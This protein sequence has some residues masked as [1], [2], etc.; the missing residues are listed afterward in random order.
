MPKSSTSPLFLG[1]IW[2]ICF[3]FTIILLI[4]VNWNSNNTIEKISF[5]NKKEFFF[6]FLYNEK[7]WGSIFSLKI[8]IYFFYFLW[9][10]SSINNIGNINYFSYI[11]GL[12]LFII[13]FL[14]FVYIKNSNI[15]FLIILLLLQPFIILFF[16]LYIFL[17]K[18]TKWY[19]FIKYLPQT[20][21]LKKFDKLEKK[22][23]ENKYYKINLK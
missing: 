13:V 17:I 20:K 2:F 21:F 22:Y 4:N 18:G 1:I 16:Y 14:I 10:I 23:A 19:K 15:I 3:I 8:A 9:F 11:L 12:F 7:V 5:I 6:S